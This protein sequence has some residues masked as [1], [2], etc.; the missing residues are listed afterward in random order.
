MKFVS[1]VPPE[2]LPEF[3]TPRLGGDADKGRVALG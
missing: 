1:G 2:I 3:F